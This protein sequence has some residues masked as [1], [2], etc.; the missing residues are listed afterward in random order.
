MRISYC[1]CDFYG[2]MAQEMCN[3]EYALDLI[4]VQHYLVLKANKRIIL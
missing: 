2:V 4:T 1:V 3:M